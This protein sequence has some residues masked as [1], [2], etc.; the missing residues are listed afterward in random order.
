MIYDRSREKLEKLY[1]VI[2]FEILQDEL[3]VNK[4][5]QIAEE[6]HQAQ[7][8]VVSSTQET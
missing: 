5:E 4:V 6:A 3:K 1:K 7:G 2:S 8:R